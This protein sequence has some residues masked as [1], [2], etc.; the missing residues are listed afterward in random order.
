[1]WYNCLSTQIGSALR[2]YEG[3]GTRRGLFVNEKPSP[4][5]GLFLSLSGAEAPEG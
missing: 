4:G 1:M 3:P 2:T 5:G